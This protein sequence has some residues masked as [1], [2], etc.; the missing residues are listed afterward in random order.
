[1]YFNPT[2]PPNLRINLL[3]LLSILIKNWRRSA[4]KAS[5]RRC[6]RAITSP[7]PA[8]SA[9]YNTVHASMSANIVNLHH[10]TVSAAGLH[11]FFFLLFFCYVLEI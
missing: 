3:S 10:S 9:S 11:F 5:L 4:T 1:M 2:P 6:H 7:S 8:S